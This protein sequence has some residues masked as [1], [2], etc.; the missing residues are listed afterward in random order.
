MDE[1]V[2]AALVLD[3]AE[4]LGVVEPLYLASRA[5]H[6]LLL[7]L[8][9]EEATCGASARAWLRGRADPA[10]GPPRGHKHGQPAGTRPAGGANDPRE[11]DAPVAGASVERVFGKEVAE[12]T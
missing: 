11:R 5:F 10:R 6:L 12:G 1:Q 2:P 4:A 9:G 3:E 8:C 7:R